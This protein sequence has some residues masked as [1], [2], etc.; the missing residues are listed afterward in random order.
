[1]TKYEVVLRDAETNKAITQAQL[2]PL[3]DKNETE[4]K[5]TMNCRWMSLEEIGGVYELIKEQEEMLE[6]KC[7]SYT[8]TKHTNT[9][10]SIKTGKLIKSATTLRQYLKQGIILLELKTEVILN[11]DKDGKAIP[12]LRTATKKYALKKS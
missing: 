3:E 6:T 11:M 5:T 2:F 8:I 9:I 10:K 1:M 7:L 12:I 4:L